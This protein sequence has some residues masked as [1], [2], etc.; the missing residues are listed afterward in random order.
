M[1]ETQTTLP[2]DH[3]VNVDFK[4]FKFRFKKDKLGNQRNSFE[5]K[6]PVPSVEGLSAIVING[7]KELELLQ[8]VVSDYVRGVAAGIIG[9]DEKISGQENFPA[10][11]LS[12]TSIA[13]EDRTDRRGAT[14]PIALWTEFSEDYM[15]IMPAATGKKEEAIAAAV[16]VYLKKFAQ[17]KTDKKSLG[18]L[19]NQLAIY[20]NTTSR[21]EDFSEII[22]LLNKKVDVYLNSDEAA[23]LAAVL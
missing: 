12:W 7:G 15:K 3:N 22:E 14:I 19:K 6:L 21:G 23:Q 16:T 9:D 4:E 8:E 1:S 13:N 11:K 2:A 10:D 18:V 5:L 20:M 17:I